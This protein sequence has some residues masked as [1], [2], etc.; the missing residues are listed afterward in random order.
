MKKNIISSYIDGIKDTQRGEKYSTILRYFFPEVVTALLLY[1]LPFWLDSYFIAHL[2]STS[3]YATL[4]AT[5]NLLHFITKLAEALS[6]GTIILAGR[7]NGIGEYKKVGRSVRDSFWSAC[8]LGLFFSSILYFGASWIYSWYGVPADIVHLGVPFLRVRAIGVFLIFLYMACIGFLRSIKNTRTPMNIFIIGSIF[9]IFLDYALIFGNFGFPQMG[10][11]GSAVASVIQYAVMCIA[12]FSYIFFD[13]RNRKYGIQLFSG[14]KE[15][16]YMKDLL[17]LSWPIVLDKSTMA[18]AYIWLCK[19]IAPMG[20]ASVAAFCIV[21]DMERFAFL[22]AIACAQI[23]TFLVSNDLGKQAWDD[24]KTNIK[25]CVFIASLMTLTLLGLFSLWPGYVIQLFDRSGDFTAFAARAFPLLSVLVIFDLL[26]LILAGALRGAANVKTVMK[27]RLLIVFGYF[28]PVSYLFAHMPLENQLL[29]F[30]L[31]YG[32][33][34]IGSGIM[35]IFY[36][37]RFRSEGWKRV[38]T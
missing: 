1:S 6:V 27:V 38:S 37:N 14:V 12:A 23:I 18:I 34:Y 17:K 19:M 24:I 16:G 4:G 30:V 29:R 32:S 10:L 26:Q 33:F 9:F 3:M 15:K 13:K 11:Q 20:T 22:P 36:I 5:N 25:K 7:F 21:K 31:I 35:S 8:I 28:I 2:K